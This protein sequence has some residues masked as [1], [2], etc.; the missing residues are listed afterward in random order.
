MIFAILHFLGGY[1]QI[2]LSGPHQERFL[3]ICASKQICIWRLIRK[4][5]HYIFYI[6]KAGWKELDEIA[7]KTGCTYQCLSKRGLPFLFRRYKKRKVFILSLMISFALFYILSLFLW[8]IQA[9]GCYSHSEEEIIDY[10][11]E[12]GIKSGTKISSISCHK[13]EEQIRKDYKDIAWVSCDLKGTLLTVTIKETLDNE[14]IAEE[15]ESVP[16]NL[17]ASKDGT[18]DSI[19]VRSGSAKVKKGDKVKAGDVLISGLVELYDDSGQ[20]TETTNVMAKGDIYAITKQVY[21]DTF[22]LLYYKKDYT[23]NTATSLQFLVGKHLF[24]LPEKKN[25]FQNYDEKTKQ[26]MLHIGPQLYLP[27]SIFVT[28][29][30]ECKI[31]EHKYSKKEALQE[32]KSRLALFEKEQEEKGL[33]ILKNNVKI[34][35]DENQCTAKGTLMIRERFG[36]IQEIGS[37]SDLIQK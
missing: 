34:D 18:I 11:K 16:C 9:K 22:E 21:S 23:G 26:I 7:V 24:S 17:I 28:T 32:A 1:C 8:Q 20:L 30:L 37:S 2:A 19:I 10:L 25:H 35:C 4:D 29:K 31:V 6:S 13:L 36:K 33:E 5:S 15:K 12:K 27:C 3:N 14:T